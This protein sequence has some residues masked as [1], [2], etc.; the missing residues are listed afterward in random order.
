VSLLARQLLPRMGS[1]QRIL[2]D[3]LVKHPVI[4]YMET[5]VDDSKHAAVATLERWNI[6]IQQ[7]L[8]AGSARKRR[9]R[10]L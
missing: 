4:E 9:G 6:D 10:S 5:T 1:L 7:A 8:I 3:I 2:A